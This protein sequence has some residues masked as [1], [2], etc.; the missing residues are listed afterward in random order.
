VTSSG[1]GLWRWAPFSPCTG[2]A[3][4]TTGSPPSSATSGFG[5]NSH[6]RRRTPFRPHCY[7]RYLKRSFPL[8][9]CSSGNGKRP[10]WCRKIFSLAHAAILHSSM[11][12]MSSGMEEC[13]ITAWAK[14][15]MPLAYAG[16]LHSSMPEMSEEGLI[17]YI[18]YTS[19]LCGCGL[20]V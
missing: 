18:L 5:P 8:E 3:A 1:V 19:T 11:L 15:N 12:E 14:D 16:I 17:F 9:N 6:R 20:G 4:F 7:K 10:C 2:S 13:K